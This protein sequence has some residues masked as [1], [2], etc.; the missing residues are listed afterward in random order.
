MNV[1]KTIIRLLTFRLTREEMLHFSWR[2]F[3]A[4]LIGTWIVGIGRN[5]DH[6]KASLLQHLGVGLVIYI[7]ILAGFI[8]VIVKPFFVEDWTYFRIVTLSGLRHFLPF[9]M[10]SP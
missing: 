6:E 7:F 1:G 2:H 9:C 4:G 5:W 10:P 8:W 3:M